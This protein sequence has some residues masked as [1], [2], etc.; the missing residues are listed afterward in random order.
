MT[1]PGDFFSK[2]RRRAN[3]TQSNVHTVDPDASQQEAEDEMRR[4]SLEEKR[5]QR[6]KKTQSESLPKILGY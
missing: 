5:S 1:I 2:S 6:G 4:G 3:R